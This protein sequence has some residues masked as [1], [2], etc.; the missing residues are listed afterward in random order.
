LY[1]TRLKRLKAKDGTPFAI[2][3]PVAGL[4]V[5]STGNRILPGPHWTG[6]VELQEDKLEEPLHWREPRMIFVNSVSDLFHENLP[7][8]AIDR[9]FAVM[10]LCPQHTF[11]VLTKRAERMHRYCYFRNEDHGNQA[12]RQIWPWMRQWIGGKMQHDGVIQWPPP[13]VWLGVSVEDK[14]RK[15]RIDW[16]RKVPAAV[17]FVSF[18]PLLEDLGDVDLNGIHWGIVG[19]ESGPRARAGDIVWARSLLVQMRLA[20]VAPFIKQ[21]GRYPRQSGMGTVPG[22]ADVTEIYRL[23]DPK[24][25]DPDEW[26]PDLRVREYPVARTVNLQTVNRSREER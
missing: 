10:A 14:P 17:R 11:Q 4:R 13:N 16:L 20:G 7:D 5:D 24:G 12:K 8:E 6:V 23:K 9:V 22:G 2:M 26:A 18:E 1:A 15:D 21:L 19:F 25:G 3:N